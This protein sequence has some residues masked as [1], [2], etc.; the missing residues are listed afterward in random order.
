MK[1]TG[2]ELF[3]VPPRWLFLKI[4]TDEGIVGWGEPVL[5][6]KAETTATCVSEMMDY[7]MGRDPRTI[8]RHWQ[9]LM[10][11]GFYRGGGVINS[12]ASGIDQALW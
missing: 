4:E 5:E 2:Y 6:A 7:L 3:L 12:A 9:R 10:K 8:E 11:G 1:I